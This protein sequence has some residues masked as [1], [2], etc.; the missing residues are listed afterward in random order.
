[1]IAKTSL[2][3]RLRAANKDV[4]RAIQPFSPWIIVAV[5]CALGVATFNRM[6]PLDSPLIAPRQYVQKFDF[7]TDERPGSCLFQAIEELPI[8]ERR[9][10]S[11]ACNLARET[12]RNE[13]E[14]VRQATRT[15]NAAE[16]ELKQSW[17]QTLIAFLQALLTV[18][19]SGP[20]DVRRAI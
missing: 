18:L 2:P 14:M 7:E 12:L 17:Q 19:G 13:R 3:Q 15:T 6:I 1:M 5:L 16:E 4:F 20:I 8:E 10:K 11:E 9:A